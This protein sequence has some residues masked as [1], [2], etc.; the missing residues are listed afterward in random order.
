M[1]L[2]D[3][4]TQRR[5]GVQGGWCYDTIAA[6]DGVGIAADARW[7]VAHQIDGESW[8]VCRLVRV[9]GEWETMQEIQYE[10]ESDAWAAAI[11]RCRRGVEDSMSLVR[12]T[13]ARQGML[14]LDVDEETGEVR[15]EAAA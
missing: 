8:F 10:R 2:P 3:V 13:L 7:T 6:L 14:A 15:E 12:A 11:D 9:D 1:E 4:K 5:F